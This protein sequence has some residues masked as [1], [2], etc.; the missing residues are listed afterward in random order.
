MKELLAFVK[1][2]NVK[3]R[4]WINAA[5]G[6]AA[7]LYPEDEAYW[8]ERGISTVAELER[9][10]LITFIYDGHKDAY[11]FRNRGYDFDSMS[12]A[13]LEAEADRIGDA[14][15]AENKRMDEMYARNTADF[16]KQ[17]AKYLEMAG[18]REAA[19]RWI[20]QAEGLEKEY[21]AGYICYS[22]GLP[23]KMEGEFKQLIAA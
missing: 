5:P 3:T 23:Y 12:M 13:E 16:E 8:V 9:E 15:E 6:R 1:A 4:E 22:L 19:I 17:V 10:N 18:S 21:D 7:G 2:E 14:I 11:G 20:L